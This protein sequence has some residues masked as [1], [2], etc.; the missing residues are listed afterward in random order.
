MGFLWFDESIRDNGR[1][2]AGALVYCDKDLSPIIQNEWKSMGLDPTQFE[3]KSS[4]PKAGNKTA[5]EA[6]NRLHNVLRDTKIG[7]V[8]CPAS[9]RQ[10][11]GAYGVALVKQ[12]TQKNIRP[13]R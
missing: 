10:A 13:F 12:I 9:D 3:F 1:F 11:L 6:R 8:I 7:I 2:I 4:A 5:I